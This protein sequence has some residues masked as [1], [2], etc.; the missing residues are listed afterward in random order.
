MTPYFDWQF[1]APLPPTTPPCPRPATP[2]PAVQSCMLLQYERTDTGSARGRHGKIRHN[3][4]A[5]CFTPP[6][7]LPAHTFCRRSSSGRNYTDHGK[8]PCQGC[9][10]RAEPFQTGCDGA[11]EGRPCWPTINAASKLRC[12]QGEADPLLL[13]LV[14]SGG[15]GATTSTAQSLVPVPFETLPVAHSQP[16]RAHTPL[17]WSSAP[18]PHMSCVRRLCMTA[19]LRG[20]HVQPS[21]ARLR[22]RCICSPAHT[23]GD[24]CRNSD[25]PCAVTLRVQRRSQT[26]AVLC[27]C[28]LP[29]RLC[30]EPLHAS[31]TV[32]ETGPPFVA[33]PHPPLSAYCLLA[34]LR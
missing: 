15:S 11:A 9:H 6:I 14:V 18:P 29:P 21:D 4:R 33:L 26:V 16:L 28:A 12:S 30:S 31:P 24:S 20:M 19:P 17:R 7:L 5:S 13:R 32:H 23:Y 27:A 10:C 1:R 2:R 34:S 22:V 25:R 3:E 8:A